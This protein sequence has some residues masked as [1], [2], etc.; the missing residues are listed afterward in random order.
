MIIGRAWTCSDVR[1]L[2]TAMRLSIKKFSALLAVE[3][4]TVSRWRS[5][6]PPGPSSQA[7]LDAALA[8][9][10]SSTQQRFVELL[11][12]TA[13]TFTGRRLEPESGPGNPTGPHGSE[14]ADEGLDGPWTSESA[15]RIIDVVADSD[16]MQR[17]R[18]LPLLGAALTAPAHEW[19]LAT[20]A[21]GPSGTRGPRVQLSTVDQVDAITA[22]L[23]H[24]DD[25]HG[26]ST[27]LAMVQTHLRYVAGLLRNRTYDDIV[28]KRLLS[29][30]AELL[31]LAGWLAFDSGDHAPAQRY[32][33]AALRA[34]H[35]AGDRALA[36]NILGFMSCQAKDLGRPQDATLL[37]E[38]AKAGYRGASPRVSTILHLRAAEAHACGGDPTATRRA[39][40]NAFTALDE[41]R[42]SSGPDWSYW[43]DG[44]QAH[45]Q[46]GFA[47]L[48]L[49][50]HSDAR[51]HLCTA[52]SLQNDT[53]TRES[54]LRYTLLATTH[55]HHSD[56]DVE[57][58]VFYAGT[59]VKILSSDVI[60]ARCVE[61]LT[62]IARHF[63]P[64][65]HRPAVRELTEQ[66]SRLHASPTEGTSR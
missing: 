15:L 40:D 16:D 9:A 3:E 20:P 55:L 31:R 26:A 38:T 47:C 43:I 33:V 61:H 29:S 64:H 41:T 8:A 46:A 21:A 28:G 62:G 6:S 32:W 2:Q 51:E 39:L 30:A 63:A 12:G 24:M 1:D 4:S 50:Q 57:Q 59:A 36:A 49:G 19:L 18:F 17:R 13:E 37:A 54:A 35:H 5:G 66:I 44:A 23:R 10:D 58:A 52:L 34:A 7:K 53:T 11:A 25:Q 48:Q 27:L 60:S 14:I 65:R 22:S 45:A 56:T 42:N